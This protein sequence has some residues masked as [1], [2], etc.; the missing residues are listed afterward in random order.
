MNNIRK[1]FLMNKYSISMFINRSL[2]SH[3][4]FEY[5]ITSETLLASTV[6]IFLPY[7]MA[8]GFRHVIIFIVPRSVKP[9][10]RSLP[11]ICDKAAS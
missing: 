4:W 2:F 7:K 3:T 1:L 6:S 9:I 8:A 10:Y 11:A 5:R